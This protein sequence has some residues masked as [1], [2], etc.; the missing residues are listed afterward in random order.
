MTKT[1]THQPTL[2]QICACGAILSLD[3]SLC[4]ADCGL[5][6][7]AGSTFGLSI[8]RQGGLCVRK[9]RP[10]CAR[11]NDAYYMHI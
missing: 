1:N 6:Q 3:T 11:H 9:N 4:N 7:I 5:A 2:R 10:V 8:R